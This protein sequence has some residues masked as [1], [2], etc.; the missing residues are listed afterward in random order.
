[1]GQQIFG[2]FGRGF[3]GNDLGASGFGTSGFGTSGFGAKG[4]ATSASVLAVAL[5]MAGGALAQDSVDAQEAAK[6]G[7]AHDHPLREDTV[8]VTGAAVETLTDEALQPNDVFTI[9]DLQ[10]GVVAGLGD[11]LASAPGLASSSFGPAAS[12]PV[13]RGLGGD[14]VRVLRNGVGL[15]DVSTL[16]P[17]HAVTVE[18]TEAERIEILRGAS[19]IAY[20]GNAVGGVINVVDAA[21]AT[22]DVDGLFDGA[23]RVGASSVDNGTQV[24]GRVS[25]QTGNVVWSLE[26]VN[27]KANPFEIPGFAESAAFMAAEEAE[28]E[29]HAGEMHAGEPHAGEEHHEEEEA[30]GLVENTDFDFK[31]IG[32]GGSYVA[33]WGYAGVSVK[34]YDANYGLPGEHHHHEE[35]EAHAGD[36]HAGEHH[37]EEEEEAGPRLDMRQLRVDARSEVRG[38]FG[39]F[40]AVTAAFG[41]SEYEHE[42]IEGEG[43]IATMF[44]THGYEARAA[45]VRRGDGPLTGTVG[46]QLAQ[47]DFTAAGEEAYVQPVSSSDWG[48][49]TAGRFDLGDFGFEA[50]ARFEQRDVTPSAGRAQ[51]FDATSVSFGAFSKPVD[52]V[53][54]G[55]N[56]SR[57]ERPPAMVELFADGAH[58]AT[59]QYEVGDPRLNE[60]VASTLDLSARYD[61]D[62]FSL[63]AGA[64]LTGYEDFIYL[65][66]NGDELDELPVFIFTQDDATL[67]G[68][69]LA[70]TAVLGETGF[71]LFTS[72]LVLE[73]VRAKTHNET[74]APLIPPF[75]ALWGVVWE[76]NQITARL[77]AEYA[78]EQDMQAVWELPTDSYTLVNVSTSFAPFADDSVRVQLGVRNLTD[79][80]ARLATSVLKDQVP[81]AGRSFTV[82]VSTTF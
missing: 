66:P 4:L 20:G 67:W 77:E 63:D 59:N 21:I 23:A 30:A 80:E 68:G 31:S 61:T 50:G 44:E 74:N 26:G 72:D 6:D 40:D 8:L 60:E 54:L 71:G 34:H 33:D 51:T 52:G 36:M 75:S 55:A 25:T 3:G 11:A 10:D 16:S 56:V 65:R 15:I 1:M 49:F 5:V 42:E 41:W 37:H 57:T 27:R 13:V 73:Y 28:E 78:A 38:D 43:E 48:V 45:L 12:R 22:D 47:L 2:L 24:A 76:Y 29:A 32:A 18:T 17:D 58:L 81:L 9:I 70:G 35:E 46:G 82:A 14:R 79:E 53:F 69:E 19:A 64:F 62:R 39:P 7:G